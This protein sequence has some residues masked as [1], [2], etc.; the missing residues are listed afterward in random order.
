VTSHYVPEAPKL[1]VDIIGRPGHRRG[2]VGKLAYGAI[3]IRRNPG[4]GFL[5]AV[6]AA[7]VVAACSTAPSAEP[8]VASSAPAS[9]APASAAATNQKPA[10]STWAVT[11]LPLPNGAAPCAPADGGLQ[12][13]RVVEF[14][15]GLLALGSCAHTV[16]PSLIWVSPDGHIW[17][18]LAPPTLAHA[19][20]YS[21][22]TADGL[23]VAAGQDTTN[24]FAAASWVS[25]DG[26]AWTRS[27][28]DLG[29][30]AISTVVH[31][32]SEFVAFGNK[33][34][35]VPEFEGQPGVCEWTSPDGLAWQPV[36][37]DES[38][39]PMTSG[40]ASIA[41]GPGGLIAVGSHAGPTSA[42]ADLW[43]SEDR[44]AWTRL[45]GSAMS[46][47]LS[48]D[49]ALA[50]GPGF[51]AFGTNANG[52]VALATSADGDAW[53]VTPAPVQG[54]LGSGPFVASGSAGLICAG[55]A[56]NAVES[57]P[58]VWRSTDAVHWVEAPAP[59]AGVTYISVGTAGNTVV[60][61]GST[62]D[63]RAAIARLG[64]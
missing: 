8:S 43:Q 60:L 46:G 37:V 63:G 9:S 55:F 42:V 41:A 35:F 40:V 10:T 15:A 57:A 3:Q 38:I 16:S 30:G 36:A 20:V 32:G 25:R 14:G 52:N 7:L 51:V 29:C 5:A 44:H 53:E 4:W 34:P 12:N 47:W 33:I 23:I 39:F 61:A 2:I 22:I 21:L 50:A 18:A 11:A 27:T 31:S 17:K 1:E 64:P 48:L 59:P 45:D 28:G 6:L 49:V 26:V 19:D 56:I 62:A 24:G 58:I 13:L 54:T